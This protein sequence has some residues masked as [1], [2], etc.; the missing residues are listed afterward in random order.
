VIADSLYIGEL[1]LIEDVYSVSEEI[2]RKKKSMIYFRSIARAVAKG[3]LAHRAKQK[4]DTGGLAGWLKKAAVDV[5]TEISEAADLRCSRLL[6]GLIY[7]GDFELPPGVYDLRIEFIDANGD[8]ISVTEY[9]DYEVTG[10][11]LNMVEA[12]S[13]N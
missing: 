5:A 10:R 8:L 4:L 9:P 11:G 13:L 1:Q 6:P 7:V 2:F 3:L 12:F